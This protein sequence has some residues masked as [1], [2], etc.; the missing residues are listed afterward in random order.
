M[1]D[2]H[3]R[4]SGGRVTMQGPQSARSVAGRVESGPRGDGASEDQAVNRTAAQEKDDPGDVFL[5]IKNLR[6]TYNDRDDEDY[7]VD[8]V[9]IAVA[10]R[11]FFTLLGPSGC[12]KSTT[13]RCVAGLETIDG[14]SIAIGGTVVSNAQNDV[15]VQP[16]KRDIGMVFQNYAIWPHM[17]VR[18]NLAIPLKAKRNNKQLG[19]I[20]SAIVHALE[21]V[22]LSGYESRS[23][24]KMSGGQQQRL[25]LA[26]ALIHQ[27]SLLLLDEPLS[28]LDAKLRDDM[29]SELVAIQRRESV[30][31]LYVT[32]DQAEALSMSDRIA[33]MH[34][35]RVEQVG[36]PWEIYHLPSTRFVAEFVGEAN[37]LPGEIKSDVGATHAR[38]GTS[39]GDLVVRRPVDG[40]ASGQATVMIRPEN[41][42]LY[43][44]ESAVPSDH[45]RA[46][47][48]AVRTSFLGQHVE[49][50]VD[51]SGTKLTTHCEPLFAPQLGDVYTI[52]IE[53]DGASLLSAS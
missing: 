46:E 2:G 31:A 33:V 29:R 19:D 42:R 47:A 14:G 13:L 40:S 36:T 16:H 26:R 45:F 23:A 12:G 43:R 21:A 49:V 38:V 27:P 18:E 32:H 50:D 22:Q 10:G 30:T 11:E 39:V 5:E 17:T 6:K 3:D 53:P 35:G 44:S 9:D 1:S 48:M 4:R 7:A 51:I 24:T 25:A 28:N 41:I 52:G 20:E 37:F 15:F 34:D 8:G